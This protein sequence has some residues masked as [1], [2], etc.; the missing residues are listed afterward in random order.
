MSAAA[1]AAPSRRVL[2]D[3]TVGKVEILFDE[4]TGIV[5]VY[6]FDVNG[7]P[8]AAALE[9]WHFR[10]LAQV[11][12]QDTG[13]PGSEADEIASALAEH[14]GLDVERPADEDADIPETSFQPVGLFSVL[15]AGTAALALL[16][17]FWITLQLFL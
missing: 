13:V 14:W 10:D 15:L 9:N 5:S 7:R 12:R 17:L 1:S 4:P 2:I 3:T 11:L 16:F 6:R 8:V